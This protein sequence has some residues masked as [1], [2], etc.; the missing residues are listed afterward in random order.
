MRRGAAT[1]IHRASCKP[2]TVLRQQ[3]SRYDRD[4]R[5]L[6]RAATP[7]RVCPLVRRD[8][9]ELRVCGQGAALYHA[10]PAAARG[11]DTARQFLRLRRLA[12]RGEARA[13][14][15]AVPGELSLL[16]RTPRPF[17]FASPA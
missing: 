17:L 4:Q 16:G 3:P 8:P 5:H 13:R 9:R 6:L 15:M 10:Y 14:A 1:F 11:P 12:A 2:T 7:R